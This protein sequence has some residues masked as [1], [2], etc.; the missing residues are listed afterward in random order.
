MATRSPP[1]APPPPRPWP[2]PTW[3]NDAEHLLIVGAG[4][5]ASLLPQAYQA[6]RT[7]KQV[8]VWSRRHSE[9]QA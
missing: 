5:V 4:R 9:A 8:R 6:V 7:L 2:L 1:A 3:R